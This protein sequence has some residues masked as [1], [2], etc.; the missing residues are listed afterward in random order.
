M[1][2]KRYVILVIMVIFPILSVSAAEVKEI[3]YYSDID[4]TRITVELDNNVQYQT[5]FDSGK[6]IIIYLLNTQIGSANKLTTI[7]DK[8]VRTVTLTENENNVCIKTA[9]IKSATF[10]VFSLNSPFRIVID[11]I[12]AE[13][14]SASGPINVESVNKRVLEESEKQEQNIITPTDKPKISSTEKQNAS[15]PHV[16]N[17]EFDANS[18]SQVETEQVVSRL[19]FLYSKLENKNVMVIQ[20]AL[21]LVFAVVISIM[22]ISFVRFKRSHEI[23]RAEKL[24]KKKQIFADVIGEVENKQASQLNENVELENPSIKQKN[25][26]EKNKG[27]IS[28]PK[29]YEKVYELFQRGMDRISISQKSNIPIGEVNLIL[30]LIK[31]RKESNV[32]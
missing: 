7:N 5:Q 6:N 28:I 9:L 14:F 25:N 22:S 1:D 10:M 30:D 16:Q 13:K 26:G 18:L 24:V 15:Q 11:I 2:S 27:N 19:D 31:S 12:P 4:K 8:L 20:F 32:A 21:D 3:R 29:E 17:R 23:Q